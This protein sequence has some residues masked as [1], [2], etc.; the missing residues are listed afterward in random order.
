M[1]G[2]RKQKKLEQECFCMVQMRECEWL[3]K[4]KNP[5]VCRFL[6]TLKS[7]T[8]KRKLSFKKILEGV[9][10]KTLYSFLIADIHTSYILKE[11]FK[12]FP[13]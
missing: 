4:R 6:K 7:V 3:N 12:D 11:K 1:E 9:R 8:L 10:K 13:K 5:K 2:D